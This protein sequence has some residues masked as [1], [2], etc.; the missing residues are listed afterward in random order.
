MDDDII[1]QALRQRREELDTAKNDT[2]VA[3][4][5]AKAWEAKAIAAEKAIEVAKGRK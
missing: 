5:E 2:R 1:L 4:D 3:K